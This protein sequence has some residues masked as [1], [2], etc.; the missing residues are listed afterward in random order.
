MMDTL[1]ITL[2][3]FSLISAALGAMALGEQTYVWIVRSRWY[4]ELPQGMIPVYIVF[5]TRVVVSGGSAGYLLYCTY[6]LFGWV[7]AAVA[8]I[9]GIAATA[10]GY[11]HED[12][13]LRVTDPPMATRIDQ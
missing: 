5:T 2:V 1:F 8:V 12:L 3:L 13:V 6:T 9:L 11:L 10:L 7:G 4:R